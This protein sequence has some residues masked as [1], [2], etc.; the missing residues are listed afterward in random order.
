MQGAMS[1]DTSSNAIPMALA[2]R[3]VPVGSRLVAAPLASA[4]TPSTSSYSPR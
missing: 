1:A 4:C 3:A 2:Q